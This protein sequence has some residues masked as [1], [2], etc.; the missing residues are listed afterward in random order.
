MTANSLRAHT[1]LAGCERVLKTHTQTESTV[2]LAITV[3]RTPFIEH[4]SRRSEI[5]NGEGSGTALELGL[6]SNRPCRDDGGSSTLLTAMNYHQLLQ[7][8]I[9]SSLG[10]HWRERLCAP[11]CETCLQ[12]RPVFCVNRAS[13]DCLKSQTPLMP[14][15]TAKSCLTIAL[16]SCFGTLDHALASNTVDT[17][18]RAEFGQ[19][20]I[21]FA[22]GTTH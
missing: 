8:I 12:R 7:R 10:A 22:I 16:V 17:V 6:S 20:S 19:A 3:P 11:H 9:P 15:S 18:S 5:M 2:A 21:P 14:R 1:A 4:F 13:N